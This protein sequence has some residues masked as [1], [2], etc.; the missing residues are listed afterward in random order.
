MVNLHN[1][2]DG[3]TGRTGG[4]YLDLEEAKS[5]EAARAIKE[6]RKA[7][8][9]GTAIPYAGVNAV[10][11]LVMLTRQ[12]AE[13]TNGLSQDTAETATSAPVIGKFTPEVVEATKPA[14][15]A[16][17]DLDTLGVLDTSSSRVTPAKAA[18]A[19]AA[20]TAGTSSK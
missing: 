6:G 14:T 3:P 8:I 15:T 5:A 18:P 4:P 20:S 11:A 17:T 9:S 7:S 1:V 2:H 12:P 13:Y 19:K 16:E 10:P